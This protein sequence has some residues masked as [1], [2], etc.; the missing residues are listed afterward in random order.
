MSALPQAARD[1][2]MEPVMAAARP[3][4]GRWLAL[5]HSAW[6]LF[7]TLDA[8]ILLFGVPLYYRELLQPC[9]PAA[10]GAQCGAG[11][12]SAQGVA[13]LRHYGVTPTLYAGVALSMVVLAA[14]VICGIGVL[15]AWRKWNQGMGLFIAIS[16]ITIGATGSTAEFLGSLF[17]LSPL[18]HPLLA[19]LVV[20][21]IYALVFLEWSAFGAV[22]LTFPIGRFA[23]RASW[24]LI[25][26]WPVTVAVFIFPVPAWITIV[27]LA[28]TYCG[29]LTVIVYR[30]R[31]VFGLVQRQQAKWPIFAILVAFFGAIVSAALVRLAPVIGAPESL[32][33]LLNVATDSFAAVLTIIAIGI[34]ILRYQLFD[35]DRLI[36]RA[37]VYGSLSLILATVYLGS[38]IG[39]Q[40]LVRGVSG[41]D[42]PLAIVVSTLFI[43]GLFQPLRGRLQKSIDR[44]FYRSKYDAAKAVAAFNATLRQEVDLGELRANLTAVVQ[45]TMAP[46]SVWLWLKETPGDRHTDL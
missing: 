29:T 44:R 11:Q 17:Q 40:A 22:I 34:A 37:L 2:R 30:Y 33:P 38:V 18:L 12:L 41:Q 5:A 1:P 39:L 14:L 27:A 6:I 16:L 42:S 8:A 3:L 7:A 28:L 24:L 45:E 25:L 4:A 26:L 15:I 32:A 46:T 35:I 10:N 43:A 23:P 31:R 20:G 21:L 36:N 13:A 9:E 19:R